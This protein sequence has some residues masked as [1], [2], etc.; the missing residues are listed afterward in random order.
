MQ[1]KGHLFFF[2]FTFCE[3]VYLE[4]LAFRRSCTSAVIVSIDEGLLRRRSRT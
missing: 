3:S 4:S 1:I 2:F